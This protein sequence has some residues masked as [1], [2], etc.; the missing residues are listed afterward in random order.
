MH[1]RLTAF[2]AIAVLALAGSAAAQKVDANGKCHDANGKFAKMD[3]CKGAPSAAGAASTAS[4][5]GKCRDKTT[6]KFAKCGVANS[7]PVP[8]GKKK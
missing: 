2:A 1:H 8:A 3:V 6:K 4:T 7:E 5:A